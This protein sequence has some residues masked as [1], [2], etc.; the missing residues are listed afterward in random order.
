MKKKN[1]KLIYTLKKMIAH[2]LPISKFIIIL[3]Q[4][5]EEGFKIMDLIIEDDFTVAVKGVREE[6]HKK[7]PKKINKEDID[8][9]QTI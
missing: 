3:Q 7:K 1:T 4:M 5:R 2:N 6:D 9:D 8:W